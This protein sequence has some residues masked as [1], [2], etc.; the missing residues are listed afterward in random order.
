MKILPGKH[1]VT[2]VIASQAS[3]KSSVLGLVQFTTPVDAGN[4]SQASNELAAIGIAQSADPLVH[5][6]SRKPINTD[7]VKGILCCSHLARQRWVCHSCS[8]V[9]QE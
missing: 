1:L 9:G 5:L 4:V 3:Y 2:V 7:A 6:A 8:R